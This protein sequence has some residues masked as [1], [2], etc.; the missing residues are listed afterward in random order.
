VTAVPETV[1]D[2]T[3]S[4]STPAPFIPTPLVEGEAPLALEPLSLLSQLAP[5]SLTLLVEEG[6]KE[7]EFRVFGLPLK[8]NE[9]SFILD[10]RIFDR[11]VRDSIKKV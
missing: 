5:E 9:G 11:E 6:A 7:E 1:E 4:F 8:R 3:V 10:S 2:L